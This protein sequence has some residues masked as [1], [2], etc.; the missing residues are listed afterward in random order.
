MTRK[1]K[2]GRNGERP[3]SLKS[4]KRGVG[5]RVGWNEL[6]KETTGGTSRKVR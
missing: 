4:R 1:S 5:D 2:G 3:Y 6:I